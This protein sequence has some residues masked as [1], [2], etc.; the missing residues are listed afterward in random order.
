M[1]V[2]AVVTC[3]LATETLLRR[4]ARIGAHIPYSLHVASVQ[5]FNDHES[6]VSDEE[7]S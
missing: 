1:R 3:R 5:A 6:D 2:V 7:K 4:R